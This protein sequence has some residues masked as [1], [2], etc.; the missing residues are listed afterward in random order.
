MLPVPVLAVIVVPFILNTLPVPA[1]SNV[2]LVKISV[3]ALP[4]KVS[5]EVGKVNVP[6]LL[7]VDIIGAVKV[8]LV[9]VSE[10]A[11]VAKV[12]LAGRVTLE[13]D[14]LAAKATFA[15]VV[16][17]VP[18]VLIEPPKVI[19]FVPLFTPVPP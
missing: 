16:V 7:I 5:V 19:V 9:R 2:L 6:V 1:V 15:T 17:K 13:F 11:R 3:V 4:T 8:L 10:P 12:P 14:A 18:A